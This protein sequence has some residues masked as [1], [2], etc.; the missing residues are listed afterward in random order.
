MYIGRRFYISGFKALVHLAP[1]MD[2]L[3]A[4]GSA[5]SFIYSLVT[6]F[7]LTD[8]PE[9]V[10]EGLYFES[11]AVVV[12]LVSLG[13]HGSLERAQDDGCHQEAHG[14]DAGHGPAE[15]RGRQPDGGPD[16]DPAPG[17]VVL[18]RPGERVPLDG[19]VLEG[20]GGVDES[21]LTGEACPWR[22]PQAAR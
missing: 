17:D 8:R 21:M 2:S 13:K 7:L 18:V 14:A 15:G 11:A 3:V 19:E 4:I 5:A 16:G 6:M 12:T 22:R 10:H 1:N 9:L 20:S